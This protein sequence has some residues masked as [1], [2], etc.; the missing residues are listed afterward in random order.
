MNHNGRTP[1]DPFV[2]VW[3][4]LEFRTT[5]PVRYHQMDFE[6]SVHLPTSLPLHDRLVK[7]FTITREPR[8]L[9]MAGLIKYDPFAANVHIAARLF[10]ELFG[11]CLSFLC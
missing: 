6:C 1:G 3:P 4:P 10:Y 7:P 8:A 5:S 2:D 9:E 11:V